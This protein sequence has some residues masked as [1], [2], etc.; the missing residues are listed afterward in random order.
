VRKI[1]SLEF[2]ASRKSRGVE[3][4]RRQ[5]QERFQHQGALPEQTPAAGVWGKRDVGINREF[6]V[7]T[8]LA[9]GSTA[10]RLAAGST[11]EHSLD[12]H[13]MVL[14]QYVFMFL[15]S[16]F[17]AISV[18]AAEVRVCLCVCVRE[19]DRETLNFLICYSIPLPPPS[20][21]CG[22]K[23]AMVCARSC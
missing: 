16:V 14:A 13:T 18:A 23:R 2:F 22:H 5:H 12:R 8:V 15:L 17:H 7:T 4:E 1:R 19:R 6:S 10:R 20:L 9:A 11:T 3:K 21:R